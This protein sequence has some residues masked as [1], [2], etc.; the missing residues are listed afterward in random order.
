MSVEKFLPITVNKN[1]VIRQKIQSEIKQ[2]PAKNEDFTISDIAISLSPVF[3]AFSWVIVFMILRKVRNFIDDKMVFTVRNAHKVPCKNCQYF[4][5]NHYLK[6][7]V[8]PSIV[9]TEEAQDCSEYLPKKGVFF[10]KNIFGK[11]DNSY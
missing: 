3:F 1:T 9:L 7:A 6:C 11:D 8:N 10:P 5:N 4:S 2:E